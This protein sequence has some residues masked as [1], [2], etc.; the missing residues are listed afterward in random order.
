MTINLKKKHELYGFITFMVLYSIIKPYNSFFVINSH[1]ARQNFILNDLFS[2]GRNLGKILKFTSQTFSTSVAMT[3]HKHKQKV[4]QK[5]YKR[6]QNANIN[7]F[8]ECD[9][10]CYGALKSNIDQGRRPRSILLFS[11]P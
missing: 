9:M 10:M 5:F 8:I 2:G 4:A 1:I 6:K 11:A 7:L 3:S